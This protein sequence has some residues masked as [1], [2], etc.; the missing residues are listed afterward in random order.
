MSST[1]KPLFA[2]SR[3]TKSTSTRESHET[4]TRTGN[5][6]TTTASSSPSGGSP[7]SAV[8]PP[9]SQLSPRAPLLGSRNG[10]AISLARISGAFH[11]HSFEAQVQA[12]VGVHD[13]ICISV[14]R[15]PSAW[16]YP[17]TQ[18]DSGHR[19]GIA[20]Q[21]RAR[22]W[23]YAKFSRHHWRRAPGRHI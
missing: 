14:Q 5:V 8:S 3:A 11:S 15:I 9:S 12:A 2:F 13:T 10:S 7:T 22:P 16:M 23:A 1:G 19:W 6:D 20:V 17:C 21:R 18:P 4:R